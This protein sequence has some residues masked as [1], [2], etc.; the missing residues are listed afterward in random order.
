MATAVMVDAAFFLKRFPRVYPA[1]D[2]REHEV[3]AKTL[4]TMSMA[5]VADSELYRILVYDCPPLDKKS[6]HPITGQPVDFS[7]L[8]GALFRLEFHQQLKRLRK[9]ALR[10]GYLSGHKWVIKSPATK[11][12]LN[13]KL[14][15]D[16][17]TW[18]DVE[19]D[20]DQKGVDIKI[21]IDMTSLAL[22]RMVKQ[23][24]L[25]SGDGDFV[26]ASKLARREGIDIVLDPMWSRIGDALHEHIDGLRS[27]SPRPADYAAR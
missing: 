25:V 8:P 19:Y 16:Q 17:L 6:H 2:A 5:H 26:P 24:V 15:L 11:K 10:L 3:V 14:T 1:L 9:V 7:K 12:L 4:Y 22:K 21:G 18:R 13:G 27:T 23:I 20:I